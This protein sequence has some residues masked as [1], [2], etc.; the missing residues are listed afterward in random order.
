MVMLMVA[1]SHYHYFV[2]FLHIRLLYL[3]FFFLFLLLLLFNL[4]QFL[5]YKI[6]WRLSFQFVSVT[7]KIEIFLVVF[8]T[9]KQ[10]RLTFLIVIEIMHVCSR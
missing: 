7:D 9:F 10:P 1:L 5:Q 4:P 6:F 2:F 3:F 8:L